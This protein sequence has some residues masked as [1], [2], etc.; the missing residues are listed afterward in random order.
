LEDDG[1]EFL[2]GWIEVHIKELKS[3]II[4]NDRVK[5]IL[6]Q[7]L[8][9]SAEIK[10]GVRIK[11]EEEVLNLGDGLLQF[12]VLSCKELMTCLL[13]KLPNRVW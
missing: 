8:P 13:L 10:L 11:Q 7:L 4:L 12:E 3:L 1:E 2:W 6:L 5:P 9:V